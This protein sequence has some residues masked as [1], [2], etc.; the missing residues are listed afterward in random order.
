M[1][2][3]PGAA[4]VAAE[5]APCRRLT[6]LNRSVRTRVWRH[7]M[8]LPSTAAGAGDAER[9]GGFDEVEGP[10]FG[11]ARDHRADGLLTAGDP[12]PGGRLE[13]LVQAG[14]G[15]VDV[16]QGR[17]DGGGQPHPVQRER[18][19]VGQAQA[20]QVQQRGGLLQTQPGGDH[21]VRVH[22]QPADDRTLLDAPG[23]HRGEQRVREGG[24]LSGGPSGGGCDSHPGPSSATDAD[25]ALGP[26]VAQRLAD[27]V[28]A[29]GVLRHQRQL[30]GEVP[31]GELPGCQASPEVGQQLLPQRHGRGPV[32]STGAGRG[33][34]PADPGGA[35][36][37]IPGG[38]VGREASL[39]GHLQVVVGAA[40][41]RGPAGRG[42]TTSRVNVRSIGARCPYRS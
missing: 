17:G 15:E 20:L 30:A 34:E 36:D 26:Q 32:Q 27:G 5:P 22:L 10:V 38:R 6:R 4:A 25:D 16:E 41:G 35:R 13:L 31:V 7:S 21:T 12:D 28:P 23:L 2:R 9:G 33:V 40:A 29:D 39:H 24:G 14:A 19:T 11:G 18:S 42:L 37:G 3:A 1:G 8:G